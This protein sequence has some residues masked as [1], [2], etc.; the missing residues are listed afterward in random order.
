MLDA[1]PAELS[2][3]AHM[4]QAMHNGIPSN[5]CNNSGNDSDA[6]S[7]RIDSSQAPAPTNRAEQ[8]YRAAVAAVLLPVVCRLLLASLL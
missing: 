4:L 2:V 3:P 1:L 7:S 5:S 6:S 8:G